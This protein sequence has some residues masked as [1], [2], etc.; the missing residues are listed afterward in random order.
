M[1]EDSFLKPKHLLRVFE[2]FM[3]VLPQMQNP[4]DDEEAQL[5]ARGM[6]HFL[7]LY[8]GLLVTQHDFPF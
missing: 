1:F 6:P 2:S 4:M 8:N 7:S 5:I 3:V